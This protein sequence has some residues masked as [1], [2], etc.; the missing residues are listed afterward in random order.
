MS[1]VIL[2]SEITCP[3]CGFAT[4]ETMPLD[5]CVFFYDCP[6]C[7]ALLRPKSGDCCVFCSYGSVKCPPIQLNP[8]SA[9]CCGQR[10]HQP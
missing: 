6:S 4:V 5:A 7:N 8:A 10:D 2:Q 3:H 1:D 9:T